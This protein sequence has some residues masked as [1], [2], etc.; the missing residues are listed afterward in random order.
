MRIFARGLFSATVFA[1]AGVATP[2]VA[3]KTDRQL[4]RLVAM[5]PAQFAQKVSV[6]DDQMEVV[7]TLSTEPGFKYNVGLLSLASADIFLRAFVNKTSGTTNFQI[8]YS[9]TYPAASWPNINRANL[10]GPDGL[11]SM[12]VTKVGSDVS[13][14]RGTCRYLEAVVIDIDIRTARWLAQQVLPGT[15]NPMRVRFKSQSGEDFDS[16]IMP[17]EAA[18]LVDRVD[19]YRAD[20]GFARLSEIAAK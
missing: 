12:E 14:Y 17:A 15:D 4:E 5:T 1:V 3:A 2:S 11:R 8:Y 13:C 20:R 19:R 9:V 6:Q 18:G 7:A 10:M 16:A